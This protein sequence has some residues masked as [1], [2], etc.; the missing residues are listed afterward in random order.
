LYIGKFDVRSSSVCFDSAKNVYDVTVFANEKD[1]AMASLELTPAALQSLVMQ[2]LALMPSIE[3]RYAIP[4]LAE[5]H[6][7]PARILLEFDDRSI[8]LLLREIQSDTLIEFLWYMKDGELIK[9]IL[10][11]MSKR[12]AEML[13]DD[14]NE[15]WFGKNPEKV[16]DVFARRGQAAIAEIMSVCEK[17][18]AERQ[19]PNFLEHLIPEKKP[20]LTADEVDA[21]L[22][23]AADAEGKST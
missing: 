14:L 17:L 3:P 18:I 1:K 15:A 13:M 12:A 23:P 10:D 11:N 9:R 20:I 16:L 22:T 4:D 21:L 19:I 7:R 8:Q 6:R 2:C 5:A